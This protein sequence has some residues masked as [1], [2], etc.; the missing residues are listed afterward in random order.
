M[1]AESVQYGLFLAGL[2][3]FLFAMSEMEGG[4]TSLVGGRMRSLL[5]RGTRTPLHG[6]V[7]GVFMTAVLQ[8]S[9]VVMLMV[10]ALVGAG[11]LTPVHALGV[12]LG[13]NIGTTFTGWIVATV[14]FKVDLE[15]I[16]LPL[17]GL[18]AAAVVFLR[19]DTHARDVAR[20]FFGFGL[21]VL[22][23]SYMKES[24]ESA[25]TVLD[26]AKL[27]GYP[28][29]VYA[30]VGAAFSALVHSSSAAVMIALSAVATGLLTVEAAAALVVGADLGTTS[31]AL[32]GAVGGIPQKKRVA[33]AH[34][35][36]NIVTAAVTFPLIRPLLAAL[37]WLGVTDPLYALVAFHSSFNVL[38]VLLFLPFLDRFSAFL[39]SRFQEAAR[40]VAQFISKVPTAVPDSALDAL[41]LETS[42]LLSRVMMLNL[43]PFDAAA[44]LDP[45][46]HVTGPDRPRLPV[47]APELDEYAL[48]KLL[49]GEIL[50][51]ATELQRQ[52]LKP[53]AVARVSAEI[54]AAR[55]ALQSAK[56]MKDIRHDLTAYL[57]DGAEEAAKVHEIGVALADAYQQLSDLWRID[58][59]NVRFE[60]LAALL[61]ANRGRYQAGLESV[62]EQLAEHRLEPPDVSTALNLNREV[63]SSTKA[64][65]ESAGRHLLAPATAEHLDALPNEAALIA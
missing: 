7:F 41:A 29:L 3:I 30:L 54:V 27:A 40:S 46:V 44:R 20:A 12:V 36:V 52:P 9:S 33:L 53:D 39:E 5:R 13:A 2:G 49:E 16:S 18:G 24:V 15:A 6:I 35:L 22:G 31:T 43:T 37:G 59:D 1:R 10:L 25:Q 48:L 47:G 14:G 58:E 62:H 51:Y 21:L 38:T 11:V 57:R 42:H 45:P 32:L 8:S 61:T 26:V 56:G 23:L 60:R 28:L 65:I 34:F 50:R 63:Y 64:L 4:L 55:H 17:V 19:A